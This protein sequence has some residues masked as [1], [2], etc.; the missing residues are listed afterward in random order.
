MPRT[1]SFQVD[2]KPE[3]LKWAIKT[4]G[5]EK[6]DLVAAL[7][8]TE[9]VYDGWLSGEI[10]PTIKQLELLSKKTKRPL[11]A[12][13]LPKPPEEDPLPKDYRMIPGKKG[14]FDKKTW[15]AI[16]KARYLQEICSELSLNINK[17]TT[18]KIKKAKITDNPKKVALHYRDQFNLTIEKQTKEFKDAYKL[19]NYLRDTLEDYNIFSFQI[20]M[21]LEDARGFVLADKKPVII[22]VNSK[23]SIEA[24]IFTLMHEFGHV[25]LDKTAINLVDFNTTNKVEK[26]CNRF[27][28]A[29]LLP[30]E[31]AKSIFSEKRA[32]LTETKTLNILSR[33]YKV[34]KAMLVYNMFNLNFINKK[35]YER[36]LERPR[37]EKKESPS[38]IP[39][40]KKRFSELGNKFISLVADNLEKEL[41]TQSD[42]L[43]YLSIKLRNL[44]K[45]ISKVG[46]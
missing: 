25:L 12:F 35:V 42:A 18:A 5:W 3:V 11:A 2:V 14:K 9:S 23:D 20:S 26:W 13:F 37:R 21:P 46:K 15:L 28:A 10:K 33:K 24:R 40:D 36:F 32:V 16:R 30:T 38:G 4:A 7:K 43:V 34:S 44:D 27:A 45:L 19:Y 22:V 8:I 41:I 17:E 29:F 31:I 6:R 1:K 39:Q